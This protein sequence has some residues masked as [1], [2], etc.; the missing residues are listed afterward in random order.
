[1]MWIQV[2]KY[3]LAYIMGIATV[4]VVFKY[5]LNYL[6]RKQMENMMGE[7]DKE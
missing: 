3:L 5:M 7:E 1:M 4:L 6:M 2:L